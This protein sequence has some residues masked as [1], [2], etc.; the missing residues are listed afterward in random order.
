MK[1][2]YQVMSQTDYD[3]WLAEESALLGVQ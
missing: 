3:A 2:T 1:A